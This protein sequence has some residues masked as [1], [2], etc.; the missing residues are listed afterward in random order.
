VNCVMYDYL[1][2]MLQVLQNLGKADRTTDDF[3]MR[4]VAAFNEQQVVIICFILHYAVVAVSSTRKLRTCEAS[5]F[6]SNLNR[7]S[8]SKIGRFQ[9]FRIELAVP[10]PLLVVS[11]VKRLN[12]AWYSIQT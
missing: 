3:F 8:D 1:S 12:G 4:H 11:L 10:A 5:R 7:P 6:D 2:T 9:N